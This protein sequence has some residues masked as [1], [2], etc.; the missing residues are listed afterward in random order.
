MMTDRDGKNT[1]I[2]VIRWSARILGVITGSFLLLMF[3]GYVLE[4]RSPLS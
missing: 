2:V 4:G 1:A 3:F